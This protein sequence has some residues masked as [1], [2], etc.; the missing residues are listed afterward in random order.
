MKKIKD[1]NKRIEYKLTDF[2]VTN[3]NIK[4]QI[5]Y[6]GSNII[7]KEL[8]TLLKLDV[9][10]IKQTLKRLR[11][12]QTDRLTD[13]QV[14]EICFSNNFDAKKIIEINEGN[15]INN[16][17]EILKQTKWNDE[18]KIITKPPVITIMGHVDHGKTT[19]LDIIRKS[20][21][22]AKEIG[23]ITQKIGAYQINYENNLL[24][25]IDTPGHEA[26]TK[27]R[28]NGSQVTDLAI[29]IV[30]ADDP[31]MP[32]TKES[33]DH[34][35]AAS[36]PIIIAIN[37]ID[38]PGANQKRIR[39]ELINYGVM[40][41]EIGGDTPV[42]EISALKNLNIANL[43]EVILLQAE[44]LELKVP[45][46][47]LGA[48]TVIESNM[49]KTQGNIASV[50]V[51]IGTL[52]KGDYIII[53]DSLSKIRVL[54]NDL[55]KS[56]DEILPGMPGE[57]IGLSSPALTGSKFV[58]VNDLKQATKIVDIIHNAK[59]DLERQK[60]E[61]SAQEIFEQIS[62][63]TKNF[64]I[65]LKADAVGV[66]QAIEQKLKTFSTPEIKIN[67]IRQDVSDVNLTDLI[68]AK[69]SKATIYL[70][71][72]K[73]PPA[74]KKQ[75][76]FEQINVYEFDIIYKLFEDVQDKIK[77]LIIPKSTKKIVAHGKVLKI[78]NIPKVG[79]VV[80]A[81]VEDGTVM[82]T[83]L[84]RVTRN[85]KQL[86]DGPIKSLRI[87]KDQVKK[88]ESGTEFGVSLN[89]SARFNPDDKLEFYTIEK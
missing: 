12:K 77:G 59:L 3:L 43:L 15:I 26:F 80:G 29:I 2:F 35:K 75:I 78:F 13:L 65:I 87:A 85:E 47:V 39:K 63:T 50:I 60:T 41:E 31:L 32:Q 21:I 16:I 49:S 79:V 10:T 28:A 33:I 42:V 67:I 27:M 17:V 22:V 84:V 54:K 9:K 71:N 1:N 58:V 11:L 88:I 76:K 61:F 56:I 44:L 24:T 51:Q 81:F 25:F 46:N 23:G 57:I 69:A 36:V 40:L 38:A 70:F 14:E 30:A 18:T 68:L 64:N 45:L 74:L 89:S 5:V 82:I 6:Y 37:K 7:A 8:F 86:Y 52:K 48:G 20:N 83:N 55:L 53:G 66:L 34:A 62:T 73:I 4:N 72:L 19:L